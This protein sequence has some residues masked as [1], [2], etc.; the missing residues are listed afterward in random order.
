MAKSKSKPFTDKGFMV[1]YDYEFI[2][3]FL[4]DEELGIL[5]KQLLKDKDNPILNPTKNNNIN[6]A[7]NYIANRINAFK[8]KSKTCKENGLKGGNPA[9]TLNHTLNHM[10]NHTDILKESKVKE[11]KVKD[12]KRKDIKIKE[13]LSIN[14]EDYRGKSSS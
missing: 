4:S 12:I 11:S 6:N 3:N 2:F 10:Y 7:Y 8:Y 5:I 13:I 14:K 9:L 1:F